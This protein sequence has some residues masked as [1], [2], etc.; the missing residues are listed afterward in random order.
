MESIMKKRFLGLKS[1]TIIMIVVNVILLAIGIAITIVLL[2]LN[3]ILT[4]VILYIALWG[5]IVF[6]LIISLLS[7]RYAEISD[8]GIALLSLRWGKIQYAWNEII[9]IQIKNIRILGIK[10]RLICCYKRLL[11]EDEKSSETTE[12]SFSY[13]RKAVD[14]I[15][16][17]YENDIVM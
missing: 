16:K 13:S 2:D 4:K 3:D 6:C 10:G 8:K 17:Y 12:M 14:E 11:T 15:R 5:F 9:Q 1:L 7:F